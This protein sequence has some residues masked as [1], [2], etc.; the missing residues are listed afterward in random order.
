V[1]TPNPQDQTEAIKDALRAGNKIKAIKLYRDLTNA[2]LAE[3]KSAVE[4]MEA[5]L[6]QSASPEAVIPTSTPGSPDQTEAI[7][8]ALFAGKK[9]LAIKL[10]R[11]QTKVGLAEA[12]SAV[13]QMEVQLRLSAPGLFTAP[14]ASKSCLL[15]VL[16][17]A[18]LGALLWKTL[19]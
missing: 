4:K 3:A 2:G 15:A 18:S 9:I 14:P 16:V 12:K 7:R 11:E 19:H 10:Y 13:D 1:S 8:E 17:F 5:Q 6:R